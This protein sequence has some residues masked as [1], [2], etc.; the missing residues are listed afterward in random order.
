LDKRTRGKIE[1]GL[2]EVLESEKVYTEKMRWVF[3]SDFPI[4]SPEEFALGYLLGSLSSWAHSAVRV[5]KIKKKRKFTDTT[6]RDAT[7]IRNMLRVRIPDFM[8][9]ISRELY[10]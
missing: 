9:R 1:K 6:E 10:R 5:E 7:E 2:D 3:D 8:A 4:T